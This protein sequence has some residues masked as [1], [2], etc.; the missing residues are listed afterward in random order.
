M[1]LVKGWGIILLLF[2]NRVYS[3]DYKTW[4]FALLRLSNLI[5][6]LKPDG[7]IAKVI[8]PTAKANLNQIVDIAGFGNDDGGFE[9]DSYSTTQIFAS[10]VPKAVSRKAKVHKYLC[11]ISWR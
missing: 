6:N 11:R 9:T 5:S 10:G 2:M 4:D 3:D 7:D 1:L 8:L